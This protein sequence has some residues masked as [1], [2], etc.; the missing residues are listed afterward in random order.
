MK[1]LSSQ[2]LRHV[3][4]AVFV[5]GFAAA[6]PGVHAADYDVLV[7]TSSLVGNAAGPFSLDFQ[8]NDGSGLGNNN[9]RV[10]IGNFS[11]ANGSLSGAATL[12]GGASGSLLEGG[13]VI[14]DSSAFNS[15]THAFTPGA[16]L[17]F[18]ISL[19]TTAEPGST[20]D[21]FSFGLLD[22]TQANIPTTGPGDSLLSIEL[23]NAS[24]SPVIA[25]STSIPIA[26]T[27][28][29]VPEPSQVGLTLLGLIAGGACLRRRRP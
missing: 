8:L 10:S 5:V 4:R 21:T 26:V 28:V 3:V 29:S 24:P 11:L 25:S 27:A 16:T 1:N 17:S 20:S 23:S 14:S 22:K 2:Q 15:Y 19:T 18:R 6:Q 12:V 9:N 7:N 13:F